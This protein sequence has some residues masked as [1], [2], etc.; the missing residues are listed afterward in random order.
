MTDMA[1]EV[2]GWRLKSAETALDGLKVWKGETDKS[3][4][5]Q[6]ATIENLHDSVREISLQLASVRRWMIG[7][8]TSISMGCLGLAL[9]LL[10]ATGRI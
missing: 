10:F 8:V 4:T 5:R 2:I 7:L 6:Q 3:L 9:S 1:P